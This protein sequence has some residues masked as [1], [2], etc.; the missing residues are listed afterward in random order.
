MMECPNC[1]QELPGR[2]C[3][4]CGALIPLAGRYCMECGARLDPG[5]SQNTAPEE[6]FDPDDRILCPDGTCTGIIVD[7]RCSECGRPYADEHPKGA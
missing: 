3:A 1:H 5:V 4:H 2:R 7:G 6:P